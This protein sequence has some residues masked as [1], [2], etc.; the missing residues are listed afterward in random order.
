LQLSPK[1]GVRATPSTSAE[2][3]LTEEHKEMIGAR[4]KPASLGI[5]K[6]SYYITIGMAVII[7]GYGVFVLYK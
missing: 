7:V 4:S 5:R 6:R 2:S 1:I 3:S